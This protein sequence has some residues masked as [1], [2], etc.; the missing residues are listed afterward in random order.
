MFPLKDYRYTLPKNGPASLNCTLLELGSPSGG[1]SMRTSPRSFK[2]PRLCWTASNFG[3]R[4]A[5]VVYR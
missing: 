3:E 2:I 5:P 4:V 1:N